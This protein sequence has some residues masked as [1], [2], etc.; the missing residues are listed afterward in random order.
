MWEILADNVRKN[1]GPVS[2]KKAAAGLGDVRVAPLG[3]VVTSKVGI[4]NDF[5]LGLTTVGGTKGGLHL[6]TVTQNLPRRLCGEALPKLLAKK[7]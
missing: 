7:Y 6:D 2:K 4:I 3:A 5:S 1:R